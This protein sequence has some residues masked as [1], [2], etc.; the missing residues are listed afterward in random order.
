MGFM[1]LTAPVSSSCDLITLTDVWLVSPSIYRPTYIQTSALLE[2]ICIQECI[3][4]NAAHWGQAGTKWLKIT[5]NFHVPRCESNLSDWWIIYGIIIHTC[6]I[7]FHC[8]HCR[9]K[10]D[11]AIKSLHAKSLSNIT[12]LEI[13]TMN[14]II[15]FLLR[16]KIIEVQFQQYDSREGLRGDCPASQLQ[17]LWMQSIVGVCESYGATRPCNTPGPAPSSG[18]H[19]GALHCFHAPLHL[20]LWGFHPG[21]EF[22]VSFGFRPNGN[23]SPFTKLL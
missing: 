6:L 21:G 15:I 8:R 17:S 23:Y 10:N 18:L 13:I 11:T 1:R 7:W 19:T 22:H 4:Y 2:S 9:S 16:D 3:L 5:N 20:L 12:C 14:T